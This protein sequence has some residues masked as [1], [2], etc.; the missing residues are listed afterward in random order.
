MSDFLQKVETKV[1][2]DDLKQLSVICMRLESTRKEVDRLTELLKKENEIERKL[3]GETIP[4]FMDT[5]G[6]SK[7]TLT[8]GTQIEI[9]E[10]LKISLP[11][12]DPMKKREA[13]AFINDNGGE[14]LLKESLNVTGLSDD[15]KAYVTNELN[16]LGV[17]Y[18]EIRDIH[19]ATL[20]AFFKGI[21]GM[22]KNAIQTMEIGDIP[23]CLNPFIYKQTKIK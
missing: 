12:K 22:K 8:S 7:I 14:G 11:K 16:S 1:D 2:E 6:I 5:K 13:L 21:L 15:N 17:D 23:K 4:E 18:E 20:K 3:S 9:I 19:S 10:D